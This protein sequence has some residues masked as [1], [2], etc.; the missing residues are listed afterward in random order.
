MAEPK[1]IAKKICVIL[2]FADPCQV[3]MHGRCGAFQADS[4]QLV[5][6][7][8]HQTPLRL[9]QIDIS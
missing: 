8:V 1:L 3:E 5:I 4:C 2:A 6:E 9:N 7:L